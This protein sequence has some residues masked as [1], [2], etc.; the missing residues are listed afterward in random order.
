MNTSSDESMETSNSSAAGI[1]LSSSSTTHTNMDISEA[2]ETSVEIQVDS[3]LS[4]VKNSFQK[5][6]FASY[7]NLLSYIILQ[8]NFTFYKQKSNLENTNS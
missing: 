7:A 6:L 4:R 3:R 1:H 2:R 5:F 8:A